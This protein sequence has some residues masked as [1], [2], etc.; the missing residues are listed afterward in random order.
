MQG[1][2]PVS[3]HDGIANRYDAMSA[4]TSQLDLT[5]VQA[6]L[7]AGVRLHTGGGA[8]VERIVAFHNRYARPAQQQSLDAARRRDAHNP[9]PKRLILL[10]EAESGE[11]VAVGQTSDGGVFSRGDGVFRMRLR[12]APEWRRRGIGT[13]LLMTLEAHAR[14]QGAGRHT[15]SVQGDEPEGLAFARQRGYEE[16]HRSVD[17]YIHLDQ[18]DASR[19]DDPDQT[20]AKA[21]VRLIPYDQMAKQHAATPESLEAFQ[22]H[23]YAVISEVRL[24]MPLA[25]PAHNPPFEAIRDMYFPAQF[26]GDKPD[27]DRS[28]QHGGSILAVRNGKVVGSTLTIFNDAGVAYTVHTGVLRAER[29]KGIGTALKLRAI[30]ALRAQGVQL[31]GTTNAEANAPMRGINARLGYAPDPPTIQV[32]RDCQVN[33]REY[34]QWHDRLSS[35]GPHHPAPCGAGSRASGR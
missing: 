29:G 6:R 7:P 11:L 35:C 23:L 20:A 33:L 8:D 4:K 16:Y 27:G 31:Y 28:F 9:Q 18:F 26:D 14:S 24:D 32:R 30:R 2:A 34:G 15:A 21:G 5:E 13:A 22:R 19:F 10:A 3:T 1:G 12:V 25:Q 17:A